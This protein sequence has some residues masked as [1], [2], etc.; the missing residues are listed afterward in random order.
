MKRELRERNCV[1]GSV[2]LSERLELLTLRE[3]VKNKSAEGSSHPLTAETPGNTFRHWPRALLTQGTDNQAAT[4]SGVGFEAFILAAKFCLSPTT[5][6]NRNH[7][8]RGEPAH[9]KNCTQPD[10]TRSST[11]GGREE[12]LVHPFQVT[13]LARPCAV[14]SPVGRGRGRGVSL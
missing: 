7:M 1:A 10:A 6:P 8:L 14:W 3:L 4:R 9:E 5:T 2:L 13:F 11:F 12:T